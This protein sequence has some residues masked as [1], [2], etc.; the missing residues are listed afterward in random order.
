MKISDDVNGTAPASATLR[1]VAVRRCL[2]AGVV[3]LG[4]KA[5]I[6]GLLVENTNPT[7]DD[8]FGGGIA[9]A[10]DSTRVASLTITRSAIQHVHETGISTC[11]TNLVVDGLRPGAAVPHR[12]VAIAVRVPRD[13]QGSVR[14]AP[15]SGVG[16]LV[17]RR[18]D[19]RMTEHDLRHDLDQ[20]CHSRRLGRALIE[21]QLTPGTRDRG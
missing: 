8:Q 4:A 20:S 15:V 3:V 12:P 5:S 14:T 18:A 21:V 16:A 13:R 19:Q 6:D 9:A 11:G 2:T 17:D 10:A 1:G 7:P